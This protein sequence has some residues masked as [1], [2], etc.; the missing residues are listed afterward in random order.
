MIGIV[1]MITMV[2]FHHVWM[3]SMTSNFDV[4]F[5]ISFIFSFMWIW[6]VPALENANPKSYYY[7]DMYAVIMRSPIT[8]LNVL[9]G[10]GL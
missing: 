4:I 10:T 1:N 8:W 5:L 6:V 3:I 9:M 7:G 2:F